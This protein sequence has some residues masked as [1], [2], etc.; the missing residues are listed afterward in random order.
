M[1]IITERVQARSLPNFS[2]INN[3]QSFSCITACLSQNFINISWIFSNRTILRVFIYKSYYNLFHICHSIRL[4]LDHTHIFQSS[5]WPIF[6]SLAKKIVA[7]V[8]FWVKDKDIL[9]LVFY[10]CDHIIYCL[11][12][13]FIFF[14]IFRWN[15]FEIFRKIFGNVNCL[16]SCRLSWSEFSSQQTNVIFIFVLSA[17]IIN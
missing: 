9:V 11:F 14:G 8:H 16:P 5:N 2:V 12:E 7:A 13:L 1:I 10:A 6:W 17:F 15:L 4:H 3:I